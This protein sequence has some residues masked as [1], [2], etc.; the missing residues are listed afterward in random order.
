MDQTDQPI[1][2]WIM[3]GV[4]YWCAFAGASIGAVV[5]A[6]ETRNPGLPFVVFTVVLITGLILGG[7]VGKQNL[8]DDATDEEDEEANQNKTLFIG[9]GMVGAF[10]V[11]GGIVAAYVVV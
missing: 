1:L 11:S 6:L 8:I 7:W 3:A 9:I 2:A 10:F 5:V 4:L